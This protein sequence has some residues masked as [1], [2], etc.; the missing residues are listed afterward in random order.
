MT[1]SPY[2]G[3]SETE[4]P[5]ITQR[6][7][8]NHPLKPDVLRDAVIKTWDTLWQTTV[9]ADETSV[10]LSDL[11]VP[12]T[13][14]GYFFEVLLARELQRREPSQWRGTNSKEEKDLVYIPD[15][16]M[17]IE[18]KTSGQKAFKVFGNRSFGQKSENDVLSKKEKSG[19][20]ITVNFRG[21]ILTLIRFGWVD[22]DDWVP[23]KSP[24]GQMAGLREAVYQ[25]KLIAIPGLYRLQTP[26]SLL[27]GVGL[28]MS[29]DWRI[30]GFAPSETFYGSRETFRVPSVASKRRIDN[31][32]NH[33][34]MT[35]L[36]R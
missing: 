35:C 36:F 7:V 3:M 8:A 26:V 17:S 34:P 14:V 22:A 16:S 15:P 2:S 21:R 30:S 23:Q 27:L 11:N 31:C 24:N 10:G 1:G 12:A 13:V 32:W 29:A 33:A 5:G 28:A 9:G 20:Y 18:I 4:W 25:Y 19:L 6:L